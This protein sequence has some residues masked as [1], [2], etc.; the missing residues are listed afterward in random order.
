MI[1]I[2]IMGMT[3]FLIF[4]KK[5]YIL[6]CKPI[7]NAIIYSHESQPDLGKLATFSDHIEALLQKAKILRYALQ[8]R[9]FEQ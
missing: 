8:V 6:R 1:L 9:N 3:M 7:L 5:D 4:A 2:V